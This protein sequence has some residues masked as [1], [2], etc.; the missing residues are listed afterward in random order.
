VDD[1]ELVSE[2][3]DDDEFGMKMKKLVLWV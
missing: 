2:A 3:V 1:D